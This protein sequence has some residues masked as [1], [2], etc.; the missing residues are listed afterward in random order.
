M[1]IFES[2]L[3]VRTG[4]VSQNKIIDAVFDEF[5]Q[6]SLGIKSTSFD[7]IK[8]DIFKKWLGKYEFKKILRH[9]VYL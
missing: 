9:L 4:I 3:G 6:D 2:D 1:T 7:Y 5:S 8:K